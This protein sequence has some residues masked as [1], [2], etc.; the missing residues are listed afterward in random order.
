MVS[1]KQ[2]S[3]NRFLPPARGNMHSALIQRGRLAPRF[4]YAALSIV[5]C[6]SYSA[7]ALAAEAYPTKPVRMVVPYSPGGGSDVVARIVGQKLTES[8]GQTVVIDNR[9]GAAGMLGADL[10]ANAPADGYT[11]LLADAA[12]TINSSYYTKQAH[13]DAVKSFVPVALIADTPYLLMAHPGV[14]AASLKEFIALAKAQPGKIN[15]GSSGN[16]SGS[17]LVGELFKLKAGVDMNHIPYKGAGPSTADV[18]AGQIQA[19][20]AGAAGVVTFVKSGRL[21]ALVAGSAKR[22]ALLPD[23]PTFAELG[24]PDLVVT[25]WYGVVAPAGTPQPVVKRL[26]DEIGRA[27]AQPDVR[28]RFTNAALEP[29]PQSP[30]QFRKLIELEMKRWAQVIK[31]AR[32]KT[33]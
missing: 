10:V 30:D 16:G 24:F 23:V 4:F 5:A 18:M 8:L 25:N 27:I 28:E 29:V 13:Y 26:Y 14:P 33:E 32:L 7:P 19:T 1:K 20:F 11:L 2:I 21:K 12:F 31:D 15:V 22:S 3:F 6:G 9:P 17:H